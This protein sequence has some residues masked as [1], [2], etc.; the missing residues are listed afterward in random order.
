MANATFI[1]KCTGFNGD[2][3]LYKCDSGGVLPEY[4]IVSAVSVLGEPETY[5]F[6]ATSDG[7]VAHWGE[8]EGSFRGALNHTLALEN[9]GYDVVSE[10]SAK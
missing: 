2:A 1:K 4:V 6:E 10:T 3:R 9:A 5:I 7:K 8:L